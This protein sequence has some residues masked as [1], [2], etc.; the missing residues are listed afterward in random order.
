VQI[1][2]IIP[3]QALTLVFFSSLLLS[4]STVKTE[5]E[6]L[7]IVPP[8]GIFIEQSTAYVKTFPD[9]FTGGC[10]LDDIYPARR[11]GGRK[12]TGMAPAYSGGAVAGDEFQRGAKQKTGPGFSEGFCASI[13]LR[14]GAL[15]QGDVD[16]LRSPGQFPEVH[17]NQGP[18]AFRVV[19]VSLVCVDGCRGRDAV[20]IE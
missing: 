3:G 5:E 16:P 11:S 13:Q 12:T 19:P 15:G 18:H 9:F 20:A 2:Q 6:R 17:G 10:G 4:L 1:A 8:V 7:L 14:Q